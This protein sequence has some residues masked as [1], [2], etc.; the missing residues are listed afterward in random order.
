MPYYPTATHTV[1]L[2]TDLGTISVDALPGLSVPQYRKFCLFTIPDRWAWHSSV[3]WSFF[4]KSVSSSNFSAN[5]LAKC[6][7]FPFCSS[8]SKLSLWIL[9]GKAWMSWRR[10]LWTVLLWR[11]VSAE[12]RRIDFFGLWTTACLTISTESSLRPD[13]FRPLRPLWRSQTVPSLVN[14]ATMD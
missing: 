11:L 9:Y 2:R 6:N 5:Q 3:I 1:T 10:I 7:R 4:G 12:R 13:L 8:V 14:F